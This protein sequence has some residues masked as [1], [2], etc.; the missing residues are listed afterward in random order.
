[1]MQHS[2]QT[3][4][5]LETAS[6][7]QYISID[8]TS[9]KRPTSKQI[10]QSTHKKTKMQHTIA[11]S[12][13]KTTNRICSDFNL[14]KTGIAYD[15]DSLLHYNIFENEHPEDPNRV[16]IPFQHLSNL[17]ILEKCERIEITDVMNDV[18]LER[19]HS[20]DLIKG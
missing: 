19:V 18:D 5:F 11:S 13:N 1:M 16:K 4:S 2:T 8:K 10:D 6:L 14:K 17:G 7:N 3:A 9:N 12:V 20:S 15:E